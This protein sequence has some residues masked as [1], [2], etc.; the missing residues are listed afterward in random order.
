MRKVAILLLLVGVSWPAAARGE[1]L[2]I[3]HRTVGCVVAGKYP[4]L[5]ACFAPASQL[6]RARVYFRVADAPPDWYYVEMASEAP[7]HAGVLPRPKKELVGRR[8]QYYVDAYDRSFAASRTPE[9]EAVVVSSASECRSKLPVA[10]VVDGASVAVFPSVPAG[11]AGAAGG[12]G[13]GAAV[14]I[15]AGGAAV[16]GGGVALAVGAGESES[17]AEPPSPALPPVSPVP[18][19]TTTTTTT[20]PGEEFA[21]VFNVWKG[22]TLVTAN[23]VAGTE[24]LTLRFDMCDTTGPYRR[25]YA[26][27]VDGV[28]RADRCSS[29]ITFTMAAATPDAGPLGAPRPVTGTRTYAV[30]MSIHSEGPNNAPKAHRSLTVQVG[31]GATGCT[32]DTLG[33][34][35]TLT[36]PLAGSRYPSPNLYPVRFEASAD[37][38]TTGNNG[39]A[40]V[41]YK[42]NYPGPEQLILG[43]VTSGSPWT[44]D[45]TQSAVMAWLAGKCSKVVDAMA[46][47]QDNCGNAVYSAK[48]RIT[49]DNTGTCTPDQAPGSSPLTTTVLS[50]LG[51]PGGAG[52]VVAN[53]ELLFPRA[54]RAPFALSVQEGENRIEATL[55]EGRS[56]GTWRFELGGLPGLR[57]ESLRVVAGQAVAIEADAVTF[58]LQGRPGERIVLAFRVESHGSITRPDGPPR[59]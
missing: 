50:D 1:G 44:Y 54:G 48:V 20:L 13:A 22:A 2:G 29:S 53:G 41:E 37:D 19:T 27:D 34:I 40:F 15:A 11:F 52:Q 6:A 38:S 58:R 14:G 42:I 9:A 16:V 55:V 32:G 28:Q 59:D 57:P 3:D 33:P 35:T 26:V 47:A 12:L 46:Y 23:A 5:N 8:I 56:G 24:P 17:P 21:P 43:P 36:R 49:V 30:V 4:R 10:A 25:R 31:P 45:W 7:C 18:T 51:V 39:V